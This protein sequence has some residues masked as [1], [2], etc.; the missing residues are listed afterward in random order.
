MLQ[1]AN[2]LRQLGVSIFSIGVGPSVSQ[3]ELKK[4]ASD[5]DNEYVFTLSSFNQ[6]ASFVDRV[7]S[8]SC[9]GKLQAFSFLAILFRS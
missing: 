8:V 3:S 7:S 4:I 5:P 2:Q 6:L 9:S 1:P